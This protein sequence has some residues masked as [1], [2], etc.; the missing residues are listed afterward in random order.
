MDI[1]IELEHGYGLDH[2]LEVLRHHGFNEDEPNE[3]QE[4][5]Y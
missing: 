3:E 5:L 2:C 1:K 4:A